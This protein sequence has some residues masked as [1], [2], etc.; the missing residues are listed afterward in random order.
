MARPAEIPDDWETMVRLIA[1]LRGRGS[2]ADI[3]SMDDE[4][5]LELLGEM[6][7]EQLQAVASALASRTG[8]ER[9]VDL[10][11]RTGPYGDWFGMNPEGISLASLEAAPS[12]IDFGPLVPRLPDALRTPSGLIEVAPTGF[13]DRL[14]AAALELDET[15]PECVI[16]GRRHLRSNNS[17]LHNLPVLAKG[18]FRCTLLIHPDDGVA[19]GVVDGEL[20]TITSDATGASLDTIAE[21]DDAMMRA[22]VSLPHGWGHDDS[23]SEMQVAE[24]RP[25]VNFNVLTQADRRDHLSGTAALNGQAVTVRPS[26]SAG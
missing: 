21:F 14:R 9:R 26:Q 12:G 23:A 24:S 22:V 25:G 15:Q 3:G 16:I 17:W 11:L 20:A 10:G 4:L 8:A 13:V 2:A 18:R 6:P 1:I 19:W 7:D 5:L